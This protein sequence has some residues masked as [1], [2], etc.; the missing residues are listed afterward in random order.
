MTAKLEPISKVA[1]SIQKLREIKTWQEKLQDKYRT[2]RKQFLSQ[3][4]FTLAQTTFRF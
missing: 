4:D 3:D 2:L 1:E